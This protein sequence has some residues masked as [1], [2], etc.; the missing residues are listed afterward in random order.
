MFHCYLF[1]I[2]TRFC[3]VQLLMV[4]QVCLLWKKWKNH[5]SVSKGARAYQMVRS[6]PFSLVGNLQ[7]C[8]R[9]LLRGWVWNLWIRSRKL[10]QLFCWH[11][12]CNIWWRQIFWLKL[13]YANVFHCCLTSKLDVCRMRIWTHLSCHPYCQQVFCMERLSAVMVTS[14]Y[15][16]N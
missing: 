15:T 10:S 6:I 14:F 13:W 8:C 12:R 9:L 2:E 11:T 16:S 3:F 1:G 4:L 7:L 5:Q